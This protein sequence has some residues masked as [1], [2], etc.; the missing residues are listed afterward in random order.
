METILIVDD[1]KTNISILMELLGDKYD[2]VAALDGETALEI[3]QE[4]KIDLILLDIMMP[5]MDGYEV[6]SILKNDETYEAKDIPIIFITAITD[7]NNIEKAYDVGGSDYVTKPFKPKE[8][9]ARV[10]RELKLQSI[11]DHLEFISSHDIMTGVYNR[12]KFFE[13]AENIF[14]KKDDNLYAIMI[15]IDKFKNIND[16]YGHPT[17]DKV[18]KLVASTISENLDKNV[19][20][21]RLGGEEFAVVSYYDSYE[22]AVKIA[23]LLRIEVEKQEV[24]SDDNNIIKF[25]ISSGIAKISQ[26]TQTIDEL[27]KEADTAL[28]DAKGSGRNKVIFRVKES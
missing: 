9:I 18:I 23:E 7:E 17:G 25:T 14:D 3:I 10:R 19:L 2:V 12:R 16:T 26:D 20:F 22:S 27:L 11:I 13:L 15:D 5:E 28:Y 4:E 21:A 1:T 6:C 8:L 24:L